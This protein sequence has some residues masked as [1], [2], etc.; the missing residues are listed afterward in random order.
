MNRYIMSTH[1]ECVLGWPFHLSEPSLLRS[2]RWTSW[3]SFGT[4]KAEISYNRCLKSSEGLV[5]L[6]SRASHFME[7]SGETCPKF[8]WITP[9]LPPPRSPRN[10]EILL[11][12]SLELCVYAC[13]PARTSSCS[14]WSCSRGFRRGC[15]D[16]VSISTWNAL[17]VNSSLA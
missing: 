13:R 8:R 17:G 1:R 14:S 10:T 2:L 16:R 3:K 15:G 11:A 12:S 7:Y 6:R 5:I 9:A 4:L